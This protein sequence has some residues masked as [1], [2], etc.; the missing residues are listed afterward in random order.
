MRRPGVKKARSWLLSDMSDDSSIDNCFADL[1]VDDDDEDSTERKL[2]KQS[3]ANASQRLGLDTFYRNPEIDRM[4][5]RLSVPDKE[6]RESRTGKRRRQHCSRN[7]KTGLTREAFMEAVQQNST[8]SSFV[9]KCNERK[10]SLEFHVPDG[11]DYSKPTY[12]NYRSTEAMTKVGDYYTYDF[13]G[14]HA[15]YRAGGDAPK[16]RD[17]MYHVLYTPE[18]REWQDHLV[19]MVTTP[20]HTP[21]THPWIVFSCGAMGCGKSYT[22]QKLSERGHFPFEN[23]VCVDPDFLKSLMPEWEG[24]RR[25]GRGDAGTMVH[26]ETCYIAEICQEVALARRQ[27]IWVDGSLRDTEWYAKIFDYIHSSH[28]H[29]RIG[30]I[31]VYAKEA[32]IRERI[33]SRALETGRTVP[34]GLLE[35][36]L[37]GSKATMYELSPVCD[38]VVRVDNATEPTLRSFQLID[39]SGDWSSVTQ[40][41]ANTAPNTWEF[42]HKLAPI[43]FKKINLFGEDRIDPSGGITAITIY[44]ESAAPSVIMVVATP[45]SMIGLPISE[46]WLSARESMGVPEDAYTLCW[47]FPHD[48]ASR[49]SPLKNGGFL[50]TDADGDLVGITAVS[51]QDSRGAE[52]GAYFAEF[53]DA[54]EVLRHKVPKALRKSDGAH[55]LGRWAQVT[56]P[57]LKKGGAREYAWVSSS[58]MPESGLGGFLYAM[59]DGRYI[60]FPARLPYV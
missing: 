48:A 19:N 13:D 31:H 7:L 22:L 27:N 1:E 10:R 21:Q 36:S 5:R 20:H 6:Q 15:K 41:F 55:V 54:L 47:A 8:M 49:D 2:T 9:S 59:D 37:L 40:R 44:S 24:Y 53:R 39:H 57:A 23:I 35:A 14:P 50:Y 28:P 30:I 3:L 51:G 29:Y 34:E 46:A 33:R 38:W 58:D 56:L 11:Y 18:R 60:L 17:Y 45:S 26:R 32:V 43:S 25:T 52:R 16:H 42:P 4:W 12:E